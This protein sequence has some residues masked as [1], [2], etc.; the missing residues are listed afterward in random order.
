M[1]LEKKLNNYKNRRKWEKYTSIQWQREGN[2]GIKKPEIFDHEGVLKRKAIHKDLNVGSV[3]ASLNRAGPR[4]LGIPLAEELGSGESE[5][6][7]D[8][9]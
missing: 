9:K 7:H 5:H 4:R 6:S 3:A 2:F 8:L 1:D